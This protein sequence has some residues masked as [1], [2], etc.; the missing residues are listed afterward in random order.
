V[1][2][3]DPLPFGEL[4]ACDFEFVAGPGERPAPV[5]MVARELRSGRTLR[6][7]RDDLVQLTAAPFDTGPDALFIAYYA[8][9]EI[10]CFLALGWPPPERVLDLFAEF[11]RISNGRTLHSTQGEVITRS[12]LIHALSAYGL[13]S[14]G[15]DE[16]DAMRELIMGGGPWDA[17]QR[18]AILDYCEGD[19]VA[20]ARLLPAMLP[21]ILRGQRGAQV[22]LG[23]ALLRGR[24]MVAAGRIEHAGI[25]I[26][27]PMLEA[28]RAGWDRIKTELIAKVDAEFGVYEG[29]TFSAA[30]FGEYL[31]REG[32]PWPVLPSGALDLKDDTFREMARAHPR[33]AP[34][35]ELRAALSEL[36]LND[37]AVGSDGR[38]R[39]MLSA[40]R[41]RTGRNQPSNS[42]FIFGPSVW[43]RGLIKPAEGMALAYVDFRSQ[44]IGIAAALSGDT[45]MLAGYTSGDPYVDFG[46][47]AGILPPG[48]TKR[49]HAAERDTLKAV[50]L[51]I[52]Y[53]MG[54]EA[55]AARIGRSLLT[56]R[57]LLAK[58]RQAYPTF[59]RWSDAVVDHAEL[60]RTLTT[61]FG[62]ELFADAG[63]NPRSLRNFPMQANGAEMLRLACC[64]ATEAG[65]AV[66]APVHDA[67]AIEAPA[68]RI[69]ADV[70][71][72]RECMERASR[73]VLGGFTIVADCE[74]VVRYPD[75]YADRR[76]DVMWAT[77]TELLGG[78]HV[79][80]RTGG[81]R[82][83]TPLLPQT[84][85]RP[86][87]CFYS[88]SIS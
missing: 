47:R 78:E 71:R 34:L 72:L 87:S 28:M 19:V 43:L 40:F 29:T 73:E 86:S 42:R 1:G 64:Y 55:L 58:H 84:D 2:A 9:A 67:I 75:R 4:W 45:G 63:V 8:S 81:V 48:A 44:E 7:S 80:Q 17:A 12:G 68:E 3:L 36:R 25:P 62:W 54:A 74:K 69:D 66:V 6:L 49:T 30:R 33:V 46:V 50:V 53:G 41:A 31:V 22:A 70:L 76:G 13:D 35:R 16:K 15:G 21:H 14:I 23:Q 24:Y 10:G 65:L 32:I 82:S 79:R 83:C 37:L 77:V 38:N 51:G 26:D 27:V 11:R 20:L 18:A 88:S 60:H 85:T 5:C 52:G 59:W 61:V 56:A 39:T 57:T